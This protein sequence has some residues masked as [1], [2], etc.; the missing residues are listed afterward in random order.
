[1]YYI[2]EHIKNLYRV[3]FHDERRNILRLDMNENPEGLPQ[4][5]FDRIISKITPEYLATYPE[6][7]RL[8]NVIAE[9]NGVGYENVT[10]TAGS[11]EAMRLMFQCFGESGKNLVTVTPTFE[12]YDVYAKMFGMN[13]V[14]VEYQEDFTVRAEDILSAID[15][16]TGV[17]ILLNPNSPIGA[18]YEEA[19]V[20]K[21]IEKAQSVGAV[22]VVDEAYHYFYAP[23]FMPLTK[24]YD[25]LLVLRTFSKLFSLAGLRIGY[26]V[27]NEKLI[28]YMEKAEST[29][30]VNNVAILFALEVIQD[31]QLIK[32]LV[33]KEKEGREWLTA[34]LK[35]A[36]YKYC[37][38]EGNY[39]LFYPK[40]S[41]QEIV[42]ALKQE[43]IWVRDY[44]GGSLKGWVR[45]STG[46]IEYMQKF[47]EAFIRTDK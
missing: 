45:V 16:E 37:S 44:G 42:A 12:M 35:A 11:D 5:I 2:N 17:V 33:E 3:K 36:G 31:K 19:D 39:V 4:E 10:V 1:M 46:A 25:N 20:R 40:K 26:A 18:V 28:E 30:N 6:K 43:N 38:M 15:T 47:W 41:S 21:V 23:T 27:G 8:M 13:H 14:M 32:Q 22:V 9:H 29:F 34:Q 7:D 24:E